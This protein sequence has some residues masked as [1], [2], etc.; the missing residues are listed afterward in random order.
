MVTELYSF[1]FK[2]LKEGTVFPVNALV[3]DVRKKFN[4]PFHNK[5]IRHLRGDNPLVEDDILKT[6]DFN[7][8]YQSIKQQVEVHKGPVFIGCTGGHHRSVY[9]ADRLGKELGVVVMH[10]NYDD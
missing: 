6:P 5:K 3:I 10:I 4:N 7:E 1:G 9:L 8:K 2:H